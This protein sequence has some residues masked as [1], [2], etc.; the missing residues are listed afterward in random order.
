MQRT[1][2]TLSI[3][4]VLLPSCTN[5]MNEMNGKARSQRDIALLVHR[6]KL[7]VGKSRF[8]TKT[9][10]DRQGFHVW[11]SIWL[12]RDNSRGN[13]ISTW[14]HQREWKTDSNQHKRE[15]LQYA[16][17]IHHKMCKKCKKQKVHIWN[18]KQ[19]ASPIPNAAEK[20]GSIKITTVTRQLQIQ[21]LRRQ[22]HHATWIYLAFEH[23]TRTTRVYILLTR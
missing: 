7:S 18:K 22:I 10:W 21:R 17:K 1:L 12:W 13:P 9:R 19:T 5:V 2:S 3:Y 4:T 8:T 14:L 20:R 16:H 23:C 15:L 6:G 11:H